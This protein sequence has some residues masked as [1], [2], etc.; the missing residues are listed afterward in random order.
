[1]GLPDW[2]IADYLAVRRASKELNACRVLQRALRAWWRRR[3]A[4]WVLVGELGV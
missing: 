1:M 2:A 4:Q 3:D